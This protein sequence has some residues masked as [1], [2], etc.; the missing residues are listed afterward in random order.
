MWL[1][2]PF[3]GVFLTFTAVSMTAWAGDIS[4]ALFFAQDAMGDSE[5]ATGLEQYLVKEQEEEL[6]VFLFRDDEALLDSEDDKSEALARNLKKDR[7]SY[8]D[9]SPIFEEASEQT[10]L[11]VELLDAVVRTESGYRPRAISRAGAQGLMQLMPITV[12][13]LGLSDPLEPRQNVLGGA[14]YLRRMI[15]RFGS[16]RLALAAYNAGPSK[17]RH[18]GDV[19][20]YEETQRYVDVVLHRYRK[21]TRG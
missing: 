13:E 6:T 21:N 3:L 2:R 12:K 16:L 14:R 5:V 19:P 17:V 8:E 11:P 1:H 9:L 20:P 18:Y 15:D 7:L 10:G 4:D